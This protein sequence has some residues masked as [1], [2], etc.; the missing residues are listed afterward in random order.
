MRNEIEDLIGLLDKTARETGF[1]GVVSVFEGEVERYNRAFGYREVKNKLPNLTTTLFGIASGSKVFTALGIGRLI[2]QGRISLETRMADIDPAYRGFIHPQATIRQLLTHTSGIYDY[3]DEEVIED[4]D[5]FYVELP[6]YHLETPADYLP[7]FENR[8]MKFNPGER[9]S[10]SNGGYVFLGIL[11]EKLSGQLYRDFIAEQVL[12]P[13]GMLRSGFFALNDLPENTASGYLADG[14]TSN[15]YNLPLRGGGDGGLFT[16]THDLRSFWER[17]FS[18]KILAPELTAEFLRTQ[19]AF[20]A[21]RGYGLGIYKR[22]DDS[23]YYL[24]GGDAGVGFDS[25]Y[26]VA[27][28]ICVNI[29]SNV[30][31]GEGSLRKAVLAWL[32]KR[33]G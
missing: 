9:F 30:T 17:L 22:L 20:N 16:C 28:E 23:Q 11:I 24:V 8:P 25:R 19:H 10:Y 13:A 15:I 1:S 18:F 29:L 3:Y 31:D 6:W 5:H 32:A 12:H 2:E 14:H 21:E 7:L 27:E 4:F 33:N 26:L